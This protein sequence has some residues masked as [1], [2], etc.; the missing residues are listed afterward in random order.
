MTGLVRNN[1]LLLVLWNHLVSK[2]KQYRLKNGLHSRWNHSTLAIA[3]HKNENT[4]RRRTPHHHHLTRDAQILPRNINEP[5]A[6]LTI[7]Q[8]HN[9]KVSAGARYGKQCQ[10]CCM[11]TLCLGS[12]IIRIKACDCEREGFCSFIYYNFFLFLEGEKGWVKSY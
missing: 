7:K 2:I 10:G 8:P 4:D 6:Y 5:E 3:N 11:Y 12:K 9:V 1:V